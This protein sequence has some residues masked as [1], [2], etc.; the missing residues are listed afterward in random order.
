LI[1]FGV[2]EAD[3]EAGELRK[4]GLKI[5]L[6]EQP[7]Q[8]LTLLLARPGQV[9]TRD[10][11]Q[12][13]LWSTD[14]FVDF[15]RGLNKAIN[16]PLTLLPLPPYSPDFNPLE[17]GWSK[18]KE[19]LRSAQARPSA[20]RQQAVTQAFAAVTASD[21]HGWFQHCGYRLG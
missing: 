3:L 15:D 20:A 17:Q 8:I 14:T 12:K 13:T 11:L 16:R 2:F 9:V 21:A 7:F 6:Q 1:R 10:E 5:K 19:F 4:Q 18:G